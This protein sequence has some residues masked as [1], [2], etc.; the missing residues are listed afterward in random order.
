M[1][2]NKEKPTKQKLLEVVSGNRKLQDVKFI[3]QKSFAFYVPAMEKWDLK[4]KKYNLHEHWTPSES[5]LH[6]FCEKYCIVARKINNIRCVG[7]DK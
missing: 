7:W 5:N 2:N 6:T 1:T 3:Q 4:E